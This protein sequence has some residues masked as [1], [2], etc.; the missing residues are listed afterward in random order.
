MKNRWNSGG[1]SKA[2]SIHVFMML[3]DF[4]YAIGDC[5]PKLRLRNMTMQL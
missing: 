2:L 3:Q 4:V 1:G 5:Q